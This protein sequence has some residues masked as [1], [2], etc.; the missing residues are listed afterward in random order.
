MYIVGAFDSICPGGYSHTNMIILLS[1]LLFNVDSWA[2]LLLN[3]PTLYNCLISSSSLA[4]C[5]HNL[6]IDHGKERKEGDGREREIM[7]S[8]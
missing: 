1:L 4:Q 5:T 2:N 6:T 8:G 7:Y 3:S